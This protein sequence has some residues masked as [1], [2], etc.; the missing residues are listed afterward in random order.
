[1][2]Q[3]VF[4]LIGFLLCCS[5]AFAVD[6]TYYVTK[7][8][9]DD[10]GDGT[11]E[12]PWLTIQHA[13]NQVE[14]NEAEDTSFLVTVGAGTY[15]EQ[16]T[17]SDFDASGSSLSV[18]GGA[19]A[20][21]DGGDRLSGWVTAPEIGA[22]VYKYVDGG[23]ALGYAPENMATDN[24]ATLDI[25]TSAMDAGSG[26]AILA[27]AEGN[28]GWDGVEVRWGYN[29][30]ND[31]IYVRF[32]DGSDPDDKDCAFSPDSG[33]AF[34]LDDSS[35]VTIT[36]FTIRNNY[37]AIRMTY[38]CDNN[39]IE[40]NTLEG[41]LITVNIK[42]YSTSIPDG[43]IIR[44]NDI[45]LGF[46]YTSAGYQM[47][48]SATDENIWDTVKTGNS[49][50]DRIGIYIYRGGDG[51]KI[52]SNIIAKHFDGIV[53]SDDTADRNDN[54]EIYENTL[55]HNMDSSIE[56]NTYDG[57]G[58]KIYDNSLHES[59]TLIRIKRLDTGPVYIYNNDI[60]VETAVGYDS[61]T[62]AS[63]IT[64]SLTSTPETTGTLYVY[65]NSIATAAAAINYD[66]NAS[67][68]AKFPNFWFINNIFGSTNILR[69]IE[70]MG[71]PLS[72]TCYNYAAG[73]E[74][75]GD[76]YWP[77]RHD[78]TGDL[79]N[80]DGTLTDLWTSLVNVNVEIPIDPTDLLE[81]GVD[82]S[83]TFSC[84]GDSKSALPGFTSNYFDRSAPDIGSVQWSDANS[85]QDGNGTILY[86]T[87][88]IST[89]D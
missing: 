59:T 39:I 51:N 85:I 34:F 84:D 81:A 86:G 71:E 14:A 35:N 18:D 26:D 87:G 43:N 50:S 53:I 74:Q 69:R 49:S 4:F 70:T 76:D 28:A 32:E 5:S 9:N 6:T 82:V 60:T 66:V 17:L 42:G 62:L 2:R 38:N 30:V 58:I 72:H 52:Y 29:S 79:Q 80:I 77:L 24:K 47:Y 54:T 75:Y 21:I 7:A 36:G 20:T 3:F 16:I 23:T 25:T 83:D 48:K 67:S 89:L 11:V 22:G 12:T 65:H 37:S 64:F 45:T 78:N 41:G 40:D 61:Q 56:L 63:G 57:E 10:T 13:I 1:M 33:G 8:G 73:A 31:N 68:T 27:L 46:I 55:H 15:T 19:V 44:N 88:T